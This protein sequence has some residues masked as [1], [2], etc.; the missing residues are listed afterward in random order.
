MLAERDESLGVITPSEEHAA[1]PEDPNL[2]ISR[3]FHSPP[4]QVT[5]NPGLRRPRLKGHTP[6]AVPP[7][8]GLVPNKGQGACHCEQ[9]PAPYTPGRSASMLAGIAAPS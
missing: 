2:R 1:K 3:R 5:R 9:S 7:V 4:G 8:D 6:V